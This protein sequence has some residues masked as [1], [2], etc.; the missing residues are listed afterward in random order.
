MNN[1]YGYQAYPEEVYE[2]A[3]GNL[4]APDGGCVDLITKCRAVAAEKDP[5]RLGNNQEVN[6]ACA[7]ATAVCYGVV[8]AAYTEV[9]DVSTTLS[10][11]VS[12]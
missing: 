10:G 8:Q 11:L 3:M 5:E 9:S 6:D 1:T 7:A 12:L 2:M 4:T